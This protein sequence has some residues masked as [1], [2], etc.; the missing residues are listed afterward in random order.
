VLGPNDPIEKG[1]AIPQE[2]WK[3]VTM[4]NADGALSATAYL[5]SQR[6]LIR[7]RGFEFGAFRTYQV[8]LTEIE[9]LTQL[10]FGALRA[11]DPL[12]RT[13]DV[14]PARLIRRLADVV[15]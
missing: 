13:R 8:R 9:R 3:V 14:F 6:D 12:A 5:L 2:F 11:H 1:V 15:F 7:S 4:I 10:G